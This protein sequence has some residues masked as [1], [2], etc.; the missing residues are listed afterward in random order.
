MHRISNT[1]LDNR[2]KSFPSGSLSYNVSEFGAS[3]G[4]GHVNHSAM[5]LQLRSY[6]RIHAVCKSKAINA[7]KRKS[8]Q[9]IKYISRVVRT[10]NRRLSASG[11]IDMQ[12]HRSRKQSAYRCR[13]K[14]SALTHD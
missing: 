11:H 12:N 1:Q 10:S 7:G 3:V 4:F 13:R 2:V 5:G 6:I 14:G 8:I 9:T